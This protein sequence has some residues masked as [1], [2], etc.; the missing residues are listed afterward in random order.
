MN[1]RGFC[2]LPKRQAGGDAR[3]LAGMKQ[4]G[5]PLG[6]ISPVTVTDEDSGLGLEVSF[7]NL[8]DIISK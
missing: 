7:H 8:V 2:R 4:R 1:R 3:K 6:A 5:L